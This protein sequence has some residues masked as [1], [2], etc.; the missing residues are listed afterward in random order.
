MRAIEDL[1]QSLADGQ[2]TSRALV[3]EALARIADPAGE[4]A[5]VFIKVHAEQAR[6]AADAVDAA[7]RVGRAGPLRRHSD[8]AEGP[9]RYRRR[10][11]TGRIEGA[12][13]RAA[14]ADERA[15]RA[16]HAECRVHSRSA[17]ST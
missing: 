13:G 2:T 14:R 8:R 6:A 9:V 3:E 17:G 16:T 7:R 4:G 5:R 1:A 15:G 10:A 11:D 12:G